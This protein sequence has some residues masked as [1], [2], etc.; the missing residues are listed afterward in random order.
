MLIV[1][2]SPRIRADF[3]GLRDQFRVWGDSNM[4]FPHPGKK[5]WETNTSV[6]QIF[7]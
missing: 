2:G 5:R 6:A 1:F 4:F 3:P 7:S